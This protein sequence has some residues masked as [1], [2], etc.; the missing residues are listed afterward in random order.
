MIS[1]FFVSRPIFSAVISI[2]IVITGLAASRKLSISQ[3][4]TSIV[5]P[6]VTITASYPG[7]SAE[8]LAKT[9][10]APIEEELSGIEGLTYFSSTS[11]SD[12]T[13]VITTTFDV[14]T[15]ADLA[16]MQVQNIEKAAE[17]RLPD[18][19]RRNGVIIL[20][21]SNDLV[22]AV[23]MTSPD[24]SQSLSFVSNYALINVL[25]EL[26][27]LPGVGEARLFGGRDYAIRVWF[28]PDRLAQLGLVPSDLAN[29]IRA[30]SEQ[31]AVGKVG[32]EPAP[33]GQKWVYTVKTKGRLKKPEEFG[34]IV[35]RADAE[36]GTLRLK[37]VATIEL[38][39]LNYDITTM[40]DGKPGIGM[41]IFSQASAN[42]LDVADAVRA[43]ME[44]LKKK[45][46]PGVAYFVPY[47][48]TRFIRTS[49]HEVGLTLLEAGAL[50]VLVVFMFLQSWRTTL[51][52]LLAVPVSI[53]GSL[54]GLYAL[55]FSINTMT[56][57]AM[58][59]AIGIVVDDAI[60][61]LENVERLMREK[62]LAPY[63]A[64]VETMREVSGAVVAIVLVLCATFIP[65]AFLSG[66]SGKLY[67]QFA[68]TI[69][70]SVVISGIVALTL[71]PALCGILLKPHTDEPKLFGIRFFHPFN[72]VFDRLT[73]AYVA[74][75]RW[76]LRFWPV[77]VA[78]FAGLMI[79]LGWLFHTTPTSF[80]PAED[81]GYFISLMYLPESASQQRTDA[82]AHQVLEQIHGSADG[83]IKGMPDI[84]HSF[85]LVGLDFAAFG[86]K[87]NAFSM[88][89][90]L[91]DW[92]D[93]PLPSQQADA[94]KGPMMGKVGAKVKDGMIVSVNPQAIRGLGSTGGFE[95]YI[96]SRTS[97]D[98]RELAKVA[99]TFVGAMHQQP[100]ITKMPGKLRSWSERHHAAV[101]GRGGQTQ[102]HGPGHSR[103]RM[104]SMWCRRR[105]VRRMSTISTC[106][107]ARS[108]CSCRRSRARA[109]R[110]SSWAGCAC[111]ARVG[112]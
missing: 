75:V 103:S 67:Q 61:V 42:T 71:T 89:T 87:S 52:P 66:I 11:F 33:A 9:V 49:I 107:A 106:P 104:C 98:P 21:K 77:A 102:G 37:D 60:V 110:R 30:Q 79:W 94:L 32:Q 34:E 3:N 86:V 40:V 97:D 76:Q 109:P 101:Q 25:D 92:K 14:G 44:E 12:G 7:A 22:L 24:G 2:I 108:M 23:G 57:F 81:Q 111:A 56:L 45:F 26:K 100:E 73:S 4:P 59:L 20:K 5:P 80:V 62:K 64:A 69:A 10:A 43:K 1:R 41:G 50:V 6:V 8:T 28:E 17:Q 19:V 68:A 63:A 39:A 90:P 93:R 31:Y 35:I 88:F 15:D 38:G 84:D 51:I 18:E 85:M 95:F 16:T 47:D 72:W 112:R 74:V 70:I 13:V 36:H 46:P 54:T 55:G 105:W 83:K 53:I 91:I 65:V 29:A 99:G 27:R 48:N 58:V 82:S 96:Q 78:L